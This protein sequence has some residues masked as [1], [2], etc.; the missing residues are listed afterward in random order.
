MSKLTLEMNC[1]PIT[2]VHSV[3]DS[4]EDLSPPPKRKNKQK[5]QKQIII[6]I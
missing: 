5:K 6:S 3:I 2:E 1:S 4:Q